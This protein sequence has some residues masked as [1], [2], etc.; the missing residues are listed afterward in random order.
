M[1]P[2][3]HPRLGL[4]ENWRQFSLFTVITLLIGMTIGVERVAL[5]P[6]AQHAFHITSIFATVTFITAFGAVKAV[7]NLVSGRL[8]DRQGRKRLLLIGW[9]FAVPYAVLIILAQA[10]W[11]VLLANLFL[12]I[13][14]GLTWTMAVTAKIDLVGPVNR[15]LAVGIDESAGYVG[16]GLGGLA[17]G[18]LVSADGLRPAPY[19]LALGVVGVGALLTLTL[20]RETLPWA[21]G[22]HSPTGGGRVSYRSGAAESPAE[23]ATLRVLARS[24]AQNPTLAVV[25]QAG[26]LNKFADSLVIGFF[27]I[28]FLH[29]GLSVSGVAVLVGVY[30]WVWGLGQVPAGG[31]ADRIGRKPPITLG[32]LLIAA[33]IAAI[34]AGGGRDLWYGG[35]AVMGVGMALVYPNLITA[36]S[37]VAAPAQRGGVLGIY[38][39]CRDG[40]YALGPLVLGAVATLTS[41]TTACWTAAGLM[42]ASA[43]ALLVLFEETTPEGTVPRGR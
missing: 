26:F 35:A 37:D 31:L 15:G 43:L 2:V 25:C 8:S 10:W 23:N 21:Q 11:W 30:A 7:M 38:R 13:N 42:A 18:L 17:A 29:R 27:P 41:L 5:P 14:Q 24:M 20:A 1:G 19:L 40:G 39:L 34:T 12:G 28:L 4:R 32:T 6:L 33:G 36:V 3:H 16:T 22:E 9:A